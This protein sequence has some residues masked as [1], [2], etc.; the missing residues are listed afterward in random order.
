MHEA[1][2]MRPLLG[3]RAGA[4]LLL[5]GLSMPGCWWWVELGDEAE[6]KSALDVIC[7][8]SSRPCDRADPPDI[9]TAM[10]RCNKQDV[11]PRGTGS[12]VHLCIQEEGQSFCAVLDGLLA[13]DDTLCA[14]T[15]G[16]ACS[17]PMR[18]ECESRQF[19]E[20]SLPPSAGGAGGAGE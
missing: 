8:C 11:R 5:G 15:C 3:R 18:K 1:T 16:N 4:L 10:R 13:E 14:A 20:C 9:V 7:A 19:Y 2:P 17:E 12:N 6:C